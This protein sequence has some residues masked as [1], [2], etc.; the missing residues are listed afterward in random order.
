[1]RFIISRILKNI[2]L[3][4][5]IWFSF[6]EYIDFKYYDKNCSGYK[7]IPFGN[8]CLPRLISAINRFKPTKKYGEE[9]F[10]FDL[11]FSDF[12]SNVKLLSTDFKEFYDKTEFDESKNYYINNDYKLTFNHD[13]ISAPMFKERYQR[14]I[15][16]LYKALNNQNC[17]IYFLNATFDPISNETIDSFINLINKYRKSD[18][19][20]LI[21][22]NQSKEKL[23]Y[24]HKNIYVIDLSEDNLFE[25]INKKADWAGELKGLK[26]LN[27][28]KLNNKI[29]S[30][31]SKII[32]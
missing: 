28:R 18:T 27:A 8:Y 15:D 3:I 6:C 31:L 32:K 29:K 20:D 9:S 17:H 7:I 12:S 11:C 2:P 13:R 10:P 4:D 1:M 14:R 19:Y 21:I 26:S 24:N 30:E 22:I 16:N 25:K 5:K 23:E